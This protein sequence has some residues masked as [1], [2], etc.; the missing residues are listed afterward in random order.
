MTKIL[1]QIKSDLR[2]YADPRRAEASNWYF[3]PEPGV[4]DIF[5]G[6]T[7]PNQRLVA[8]EY[9]KYIQ[10]VAVCSLLH[11][12]VHEERLTALLIWVLQYKKG[13]DQTKD[14]IYHLYLN[15]TVVVQHIEDGS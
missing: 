3:K 14:N 8:K 7:V 13:D 12:T 15:N 9:Y 4:D 1:A 2:R 10:P 11:S 5:L 6:V